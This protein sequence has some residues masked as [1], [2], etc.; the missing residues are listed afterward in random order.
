[1]IGGVR[2]QLKYAISSDSQ[3]INVVEVLYMKYNVSVKP[4]A[5]SKSL[6]TVNSNK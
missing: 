2:W 5:V 3:F 4:T 6:I 1:M